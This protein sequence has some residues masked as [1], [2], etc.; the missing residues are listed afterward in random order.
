MIEPYCSSKRSIVMLK[1]RHRGFTLIEL[2]VVISIIALLIAILLPAL[3]AARKTAMTAK[4]MSNLKQIANGTF[5][6]LNFNDQAYPRVLTASADSSVPWSVDWPIKEHFWYFLGVTSPWGVDGSQGLMLPYIN[7]NVEVLECPNYWAS[8][9]G[10]YVGTGVS[11]IADDVEAQVWS[12]GWNSR[13]TSLGGVAMYDMW[14]SHTI[15]FDGDGVG[16]GPGDI[17]VTTVHEND[18][19]RPSTCT[20]VSDIWCAEWQTTTTIPSDIF[21]STTFGGGTRDPST[22][23]T[24]P[25]GNQVGLRHSKKNWGFNILF[26]DGHAENVTAT[27]HYDWWVQDDSY[28]LLDP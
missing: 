5:A 17:Q 24:G 12:Y 20:M 22:Y 28:W 16:G 26:A 21:A 8:S 11:S 23:G 4:C 14:P 2:L 19:K 7:N 15:D 13:M 25:F 27:S 9:F 3:S 1:R 10:A 18:V 6:Y